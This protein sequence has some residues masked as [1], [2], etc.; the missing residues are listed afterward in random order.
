[1]DYFYFA[2]RRLLQALLVM[3]VISLIGFSIQDNLGDPLRELVGQSVSEAQRQELRDRMG[4]NDPFLVQY[5]RFLGKAVQGDL[6]QSYFFKKPALEVIAAKFPATLELVIG[7]TIIIISFAIP[8]GV[9]CAIRP[10]SWFSRFVMG[11][12]IVGISVPVFLTAIFSIYLFSVELG[13]MPSFGR[14]ETSDVLGW[15]SGFFTADGLVHL[16]LPSI[17]LASIMMPLFIRL[18]RSEMMEILQTEYIRF[19]WAK[20]L[21][22]KRVWF[23][24]A[25]KNTL[26]PVITVGGVQVGT[27]LA[28]TILTESVFQ[29]PGMGFLFL[30]AV[31]RVDTPLI[32]AYII[33]VGLIFVVTNTVVDLIYTWVNPTVKLVGQKA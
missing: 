23:L 3:F 4:L 27:M 25:F 10:K 18:I 12:S 29:W 16:I 32:I 9:Y 19:A 5:G 21:Y 26:L 31:N 20:G 7:A 1:M 13:W 11:F 14:G 2:V 17:S 22:P 6:G 8:L 28:Y 30:E 33:V 15:Q 24:H